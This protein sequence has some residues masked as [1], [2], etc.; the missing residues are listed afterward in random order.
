MSA[1]GSLSVSGSRFDG[2]EIYLCVVTFLGYVTAIRSVD[3]LK[4]GLRLCAYLLGVLVVGGG[5]VGG[6]LR[7]GYADISELVGGG[8][9]GT[10]DTTNVIVGGLATALG[11][12]VLLAGVLGLVYKLVGDSVAAGVA[13]GMA[14][15]APTPRPDA[16]DASSTEHR[17]RE[18][19]P[20]G[21]T[22][23]SPGEKAARKHDDSMTVPAATGQSSN[24]RI[25][26]R[27]T[28]SDTRSEEPPSAA[29]YDGRSG[30]EHRAA[31][32]G[33]SGDSEEPAV[34]D[35]ESDPGRQMPPS[36]ET[37]DRSPPEPS[38]EEIAFGTDTAVET[39]DEEGTTH[40]DEPSSAGTDTDTDPLA[41]PDE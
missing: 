28:E 9:L 27:S 13:T 37:D 8:S 17:D 2:A 16:S 12:F 14:A 7:V 1:L 11:A 38:P 41:D 10:V 15:S 36:A 4:Y 23:P 40:S 20:S 22:G 26:D 25:V 21:Q 29:E 6:G 35:S 31:A 33:V 3:S 30:A 24:D 39:A 5:A 19:K 32:G 34:S 18:P